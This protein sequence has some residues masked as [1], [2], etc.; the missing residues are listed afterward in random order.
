METLEQVLHQ[1]NTAEVIGEI[2]GTK[3][4]GFSDYKAMAER[5][6]RTGY[7]KGQRTTNPDGSFAR[8]RTKY[9]AINPDNLYANRFRVKNSKLYVATSYPSDTETYRAIKNQ[10]TGRIS[11]AHVPVFIFARNKD[12][13]LV[14]ERKA[15]VSAEEFI[16]T[17][18]TALS[19]QDMHD[20]IAPLIDANRNTATETSEFP[21]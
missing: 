18:T 6:L 12:G 9:A 2:N 3:L 13:E 20:K 4:V 5:D 10:N 19:I 8:T 14:F 21:I 15:T 1:A 16:G 17:F 7:D 11:T